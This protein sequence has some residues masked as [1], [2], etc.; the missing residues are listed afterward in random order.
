MRRQFTSKQKARIALCAVE[1]D[2]T[3]NQVAAEFEV[4]PTQVKQW[5]D[6]LKAGASELFADKWKVDKT[7][8][9]A[10]AHIYKL[11]RVIGIRDAELLWLK[12]TI[13]RMSRWKLT[14]YGPVGSQRSSIPTMKLSA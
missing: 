14:T 5:R 6:T 1:S 3:I 8:T 10:H 9:T 11:H 13:H 12:K 2:K 4:C 7:K